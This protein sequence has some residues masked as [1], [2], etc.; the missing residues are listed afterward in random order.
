MNQRTLSTLN[1]ILPRTF[2]LAH[3]V[4][5]SLSHSLSIYSVITSGKF[6]FE[7]TV[8]DLMLWTYWTLPPVIARFGLL[9]LQLK[10]LTRKFRTKNRARR[11][12]VKGPDDVSDGSLYLDLDADDREIRLLRLVSRSQDVGSVRTCIASLHDRPRYYALSYVWG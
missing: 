8:V 7:V 1:R 6:R 11:G 9:I 4:S 12:L 3:G 10:R 5:R 2:L